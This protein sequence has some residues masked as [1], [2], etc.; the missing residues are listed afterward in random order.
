MGS[1]LGTGGREDIW[2]CEFI[3]RV[4]W[5]AVI[6]VDS[7]PG[8]IVQCPSPDCANSE[9]ILHSSFPKPGAGVPVF[10]L[11][12]DVG[13]NVCVSLVTVFGC[14]PGPHHV[15]Q[16]SFQTRGNTAWEVSVHGCPEANASVVPSSLGLVSKSSPKKPRGRNI[17][18]AL[19]C[20]F[21]AQH[22]GQSTSSTELS[23]YKE[24]ANTIAKVAGSKAVR[25]R[26]G[27]GC[28]GRVGSL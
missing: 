17:F 19:F 26:Q 6:K 13:M 3:S 8:P 4:S 2:F 11:D 14:S 25:C 15:P 12:R 27:R 1:L 21:R 18:K 20:C 7:V 9:Q 24:E 5:C 22:V 10:L 16:W 23:P 28:R